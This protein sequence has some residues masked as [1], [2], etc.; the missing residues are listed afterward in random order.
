[1]AQELISTTIKPPSRVGN[2]V[3]SFLANRG[4]AVGAAVLAFTIFVAVLAPWI[5]PFTPFHLADE[6]F[7]APGAANHILGTDALG[8]DTLSQMLYGARISLLVGF[9]AATVSLILGIIIGA[10][11]GYCGGAVDSFLMRVTEAFQV[12]PNFIVALVVVA[13]L[14]SGIGKLVLVIGLLAWPS[15]AR[16]VRGQ[17]LS[18]R[19]LEFVEASRT[20]GVPGHRIM[21]GEILPNALAPAIVVASLD[22][23]RAILLEAGLSFLG[24]G[25]PD[26]MSWGTM[27]QNADRFLATAWW[28]SVFPGLAI[29]LVVLALNLVGDGLTDAVNPR[30]RK[31]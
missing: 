4:A 19:S 13:M 20:L 1:M 23:A 3:T 16:L 21:L 17:F 18:L 8:R 26:V 9:V 10:T 6:P 28:L 22:V 12:L 2:F 24:L 25:D 30:L 27:L 31:R 15:T 14:G 7:L 29:F 11:A 5:A